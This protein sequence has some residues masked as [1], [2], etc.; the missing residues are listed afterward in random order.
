MTKNS[1]CFNCFVSCSLKIKKQM[2]TA[3]NQKLK[4]EG[5]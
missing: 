1:T 3:L 5:D 2:R 4:Q